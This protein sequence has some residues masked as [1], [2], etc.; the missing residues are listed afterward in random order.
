MSLIVKTCIIILAGALIA[1]ALV[2]VRWSRIDYFGDG[3]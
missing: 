2:L 1:L 3:E